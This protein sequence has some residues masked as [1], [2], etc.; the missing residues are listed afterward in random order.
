MV[1]CPEAAQD[2]LE[3]LAVHGLLHLLGYDHEVDEGEMLALQDRL[4]AEA[5]AV[6]TSQKQP[7]PPAGSRRRP[8]PT[9]RPARRGSAL[10]RQGSLRWSF[11]WAFEGIVYVL[12]TQRNM[13]IHVARRG[14]RADR[15]ALLL[16]VLARS[17]WRSSSG[18]SAWCWWPR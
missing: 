17:S 13:Q 16:D 3:T 10:P 6:T 11:T 9:R 12:R 18:R 15:S 1:I 2:P 7:P 8:R 14:R 5:R 4:V